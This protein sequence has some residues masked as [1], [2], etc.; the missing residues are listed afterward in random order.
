MYSVSW[1]LLVKLLVLAKWSARNTPLRKLICSKEIIS[2]KL[3]HTLY[4]IF[5]FSVLFVL[6]CVCLVPRPYTL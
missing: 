2:T 5:L 4:I 6:L 3:R 1:L